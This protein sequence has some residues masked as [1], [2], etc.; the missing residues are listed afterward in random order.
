MRSNSPANKT[1]FRK[2]VRCE[3]S[4]DSLGADCLK[5]SK[6]IESLITCQLRR[7]HISSNSFVEQ[8]KRSH[9]WADDKEL[10]EFSRHSKSSSLT[11]TS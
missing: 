7:L 5:C 11:L 2:E 10:K 8:D 6:D 1:S 3:T 4:L 9:A